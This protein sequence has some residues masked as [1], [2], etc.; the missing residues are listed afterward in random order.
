V[1]NRKSSNV[2]LARSQSNIFNDDAR[3]QLMDNIFNKETKEEELQRGLEEFKKV[4]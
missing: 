1:N 3:K 2:A 4:D